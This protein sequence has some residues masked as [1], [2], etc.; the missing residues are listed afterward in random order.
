MNTSTVIALV[1]NAALLVALGVLYD[2]LGP[3]PRGGKPALQQALAGVILGA[4]GITV[5]LNPWQFT[6]GI[7]FDTR[8]VL[9][10]ISGLFFGTLPTLLAVLMTAAFRLYQGGAGAWT[11]VAAIVTSGAIGVAWRH[12]RRRELAQIS[13]GELYILGLVV[14]T[15]MLLWMFSLPLPFPL[16]VLSQISLPMM[17]IYPTATAWLGWLIMKRQAR[18]Q[19]EETLQKSESLLRKSQAIA[20]VGSWELDLAAN[21]LT[22]SDEMYRIFGLRPQEFG[23]T[24]EAF[25]DAVYPDD[26]AAVDAAYFGLLREERD[27]YEIQYRIIRRDSGEVRVVQERC[28]HVKDASGRIVR[29]V[30]I[31]QDITERVQA[32]KALRDALAELTTIYHNVPLAMMLVD[33]DRRVRKVNDTAAL[34]ASRPAEEML[35]LRSGEA[36]RCLHHLDDPEGCG[37]GP[38]CAT[39]AVRLAVLDTFSDGQSRQDVEAWLPFPRGDSVEERCLLVSTAYLQTAGSERVLVCVQDITERKQAEKALAEYVERLKEMVE[40]RTKKLLEAQEQLVR[41][42]KLAMLGQL[43]GGVAHDLRNPLNV[44]SNAAYLLKMLHD[45]G[46]DRDTIHEN[47]DLIEDQVRIA[48]G[49]VSDLLDFART[50]A[51]NRQPVQVPTLVAEALYR[52]PPPGNVTVT[53]D[54]PPDLLPVV[55]DPHQIGQALSNV[56]VNAYQ[57]MPAGGQLRIR[58]AMDAETAAEGGRICVQVSDTGTGIAPEHMEKLFEP[59]FTTKP[60]GTGLGL[61]TS[62]NLVEANGGRIAV[63][64]EVGKGSTFTIWLPAQGSAS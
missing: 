61:I 55:V 7:V 33:R 21:Q 34:F 38:A 54:I 49:I 50:R 37:F 20:H 28:E 23:A 62:K 36:L 4:I 31:V 52:R 13:L 12:L 16:G 53:T 10:S 35:D 22:W 27:T 39:C 3:R 63:E 9:L 56:I 58:A 25:L 19:A 46:G 41:R 14:H 59:L 24:H 45:E 57:A 17:V 64:S 43:A 40:E 11:G 2:L 42:E 47:L 6:P 26:R 18:W 32:E 30:G 5:M 51:P 8:S 15:A 1:N 60:A 29:S 48:A 44:I